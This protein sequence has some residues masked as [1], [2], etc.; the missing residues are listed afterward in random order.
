MISYQTLKSDFSQWFSLIEQVN[1]TLVRC[2]RSIDDREFAIYYVDISNEVPTTLEELDQYQDRVIAPRYFEGSKSLQ[3]SHY[4]YFVIQQAVS[5]SDRV[6][7]EKD[8]K[9]ARKY[10]VSEEELNSALTPPNFQIAEGV[11]D[12]SVFSTWTSILSEANLEHAILNDES[13][14]KRIELI[15]AEYGHKGLGAPLAHPLP[16]N[17]TP[18][19]ISSLEI[20]EFRHYPLTREFEFGDVTLFSGPNGTGKTSL[21]EAIELL[22]CGRNKRNPNAKENYTLEANF[23]DGKTEIAK[24]TQS[25]KRYRD[26]NLAWYGQSETRTNNLYQSFARYNFLDTDAAVGLATTSAHVE[27]N[28]AKLLVGAETSKTWREIERTY[29]ELDKTIKVQSGVLKQVEIELLETKRQLA[30]AAAIPQE[31]DTLLDT[32]SDALSNAAW[33][34]AR[35][36]LPS[37]LDELSDTLVRFD[38]FISEALKCDWIT[39]PPTIAGLRVFEQETEAVITQWANLNDAYKTKLQRCENISVKLVDNTD[40][41]MLAEE[42]EKYVEQELPQQT[43][44]ITKLREE[45]SGLEKVAKHVGTLTNN[46]EAIP[47]VTTPLYEFVEQATTNN[48]RAAGDLA[49]ARA[50]LVSFTELRNQSVALYQ[51]LRDI[52]KQILE[53]SPDKAD[54]CPLC[55]AEYGPHE[56]LNRMSQNVD[57]HAEA[58]SAKLRKLVRDCDARFDVSKKEVATAKWLQDF[59]VLVERSED[60]SVSELKK[61]VIDTRN[62]RIKKQDELESLIR[63]FQSKSPDDFSMARCHKLIEILFPSSHPKIPSTTEVKDL[64]KKLSKE[65]ESYQQEEK[66]IKQQLATEHD[67]AGEL[68]GVQFR[69]YESYESEV[70]KISERMDRVKGLLK[71]IPKSRTDLALS[72]TKDLSELMVNIGVLRKLLSSTR[73]AITNENKANVIHAA[74]SKRKNEIET[75]LGGLKPRVSRLRNAAEVIRK[76]L[77]QHT[78]ADAMDQAV[79]QNKATIEEIFHRIHSPAEFSSL[80]DMTT[81]VRKNGGTATLQEVSTGQRAAYALSLFLAQNAQLRS[82]PPLIL[83][84]D[85]I[86]HIDDL[87]CLSFLDYLREVALSGDRQIFFSTANEKLASL[88]ERKFDF[89]GKEKFKRYNLS[90][91]T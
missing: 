2:V 44:R 8:R 62:Q 10:I 89:L 21:F 59:S 49:E 4:L 87:N 38:A 18:A 25:I 64:I 17:S 74:N 71:S 29:K 3:W 76:I 70:T 19:F 77:D 68:L 65:S 36:D 51:Q 61:E 40:Q 14:P 63:I 35:M 81:L 11:V 43:E 56:L 55:H 50:Q 67:K 16:V 37:R 60:L 22:Y 34:V 30:E 46:V 48:E 52:A 6:L 84:D 58:Q 1:D 78:L 12:E 73:T 15:E 24:H 47:S 23:Q 20:R 33:P 75:Q 72:E 42:L 26:R 90:R 28:L 57:S 86:A 7:I 45:I 54:N 53:D 80:E 69:E 32:V 79:Q 39:K 31:S 41:I 9:Y 82:A 91:H 5:L 27:E 85:P 83:I 88:F 13:L 66:N